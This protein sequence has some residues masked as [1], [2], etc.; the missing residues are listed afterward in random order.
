MILR[1]FHHPLG[2]IRSERHTAPGTA[3]DVVVNEVGRAMVSVKVRALLLILRC[4]LVDIRQGIPSRVDVLMGSTDAA[5][6]TLA[7]V[8]LCGKCGA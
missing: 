8:L 1:L 2:P 7:K 6:V 4:R 5:T 3:L